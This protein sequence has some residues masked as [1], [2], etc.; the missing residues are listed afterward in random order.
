MAD[1]TGPSAAAAT[2]AER[3][4]KTSVGSVEPESKPQT[5]EIKRWGDMVD[6]EEQPGDTASSSDDKVVEELKVD[7]LAIDDSKKIN[8]FLDDP[9]DSSIQAKPSKIQAISLP[10][11]LTPPYKDL[12]AQAHNGSGKT[13]CFVLGMLS[14]I[15]PNVK[16]PQ[17]LCICPTRELSIQNLEVL[18]KMGK[19]TGISS[20]CAVPMD[21]GNN[22]RSR[23]RPPIFAQVVIG[24]PGTYSILLMIIQDGFQDDSLRIMKDIERL[25]AQCQVLLFSATFDETV[26]NF[27]SRIVRKDYNQLFVKKE[28]LSLD[29]VKQ[30]K[31]YCPNEVTKITAIKD[32][33]LELGESLGQTIIFVNT[34]R[35]AG[36]LHKALVDLGYEVTTIHGAL[37]HEDRDKIVKEFKDGLTQVL[38]STD[39]LARGFDQQQ[40]NL[41][42]NY[43]LPVKYETPSEPH[44]EVY[45]HRIG[46]A[47]RFGRKGAVFNFVMTDRD[48]MIMEKIEVLWHQS[49]RGPILEQE[50][51]FK[52]ALKEAGLLSETD[53]I[54]VVEQRIWHSMEE[55]QFENL[56]GKGKPLNL[57]TNPHSDPAEDTLYRILSKNGC[58]PEWVELN[59]EIRSKVSE[60]RV[61]LKKAWTNKCS[62]DHSKWIEKT[63]TLKMQM[64]DIN[65]KIF[66]YNL[67]VPFGRQMFGLKWEKELDRLKE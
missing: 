59:K 38:I 27:V 10:M 9:E 19:Y 57:S 7:K 16:R 37:T 29:S 66:R 39:V 54:N 64:G 56:P 67:I 24:T 62:G 23:S 36:M 11:I 50:E 58:A 8:K 33:I 1:A 41:V 6:D 51:D 17:A 5:A 40:V 47:G 15:N 14:R 46:R 13:T 60:W 52:A 61:A 63:V 30:Y 25:N 22:D 2:S 21:S 28:E 18:Q 45:L 49:K 4:K 42:I 65:D 53:I 32:R 26:K 48:M 3:E 12:I 31:V 34:K 43:D 35:S 44:Y 20:E 55:G